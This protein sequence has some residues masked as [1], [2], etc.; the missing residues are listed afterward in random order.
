MYEIKTRTLSRENNESDCGVDARPSLFLVIWAG[1]TDP[2]LY[3]LPL[4][5]P[6]YERDGRNEILVNELILLT[7]FGTFLPLKYPGFPVSLFA[8]I[9]YNHQ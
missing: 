1:L 2:F 6:L 8:Y 7:S 3:R 4:S 5:L 9:Y